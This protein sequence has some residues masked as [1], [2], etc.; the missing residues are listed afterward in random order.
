[1]A[2]KIVDSRVLLKHDTTANW[3][4]IATTF[5]PMNGEMIIYD[6]YYPIWERNSDGSYV[7]D[8]AGNKIQRYEENKY[9]RWVP[10]FRPGVKIGTGTIYLCDLPFITI[11]PEIEEKME[12][13]NNKLNVD[14]SPEGCQ[15]MADTETL[16]FNRN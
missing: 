10:L 6:D 5:T 13:W 15:Y 12:F 4:L 7:L 2:N 8:S 11:T 9:G 16:I 3:N 1:M 14:D